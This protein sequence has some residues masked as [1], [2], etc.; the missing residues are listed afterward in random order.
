L[1]DQHVLAQEVQTELV[2]ITAAVVQQTV[3]AATNL[4]KSARPSQEAMVAVTTVKTYNK[5]KLATYAINAIGQVGVVPE[6]PPGK[7]AS[8]TG[9]E[10]VKRA[11]QDADL[12]GILT[13]GDAWCRADEAASVKRGRGDQESAEGGKR[14]E[15][16]FTSPHGK[17]RPR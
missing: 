14:T 4:R 16:G 8:W 3:R 13:A 12:V 11:F 6:L 17:C 10:P 5:A 9:S 7:N 2:G 15:S 1:D